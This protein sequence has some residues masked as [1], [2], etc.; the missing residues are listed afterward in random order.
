[1]I[2]SS[3]MCR[4]FL[5]K[6]KSNAACTCFLEAEDHGSLF[7]GTAACFIINFT[8]LEPRSNKGILQT[9]PKSSDV[10]DFLRT[11][12]QQEACHEDG[13]TPTV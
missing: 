6:K 10:M 9:V 1:M 12:M 7:E 11:Q 3:F 13:Y 5:Q 4:I 2:L 8:D